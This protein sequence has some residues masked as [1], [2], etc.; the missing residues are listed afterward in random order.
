M[1][2]CHLLLLFALFQLTTFVLTITS[3]S[4]NEPAYIKDEVK[5]PY[6]LY[7]EGKNE[8]EFKLPNLFFPAILKQEEIFIAKIYLHRDES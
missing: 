5:D 6:K 8:F 4:K 1:H 2:Y 3:C 7:Q